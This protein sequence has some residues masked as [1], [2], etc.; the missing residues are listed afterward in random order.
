MA[1][2]LFAIYGLLYTTLNAKT[3]ALL[4]GSIGLWVTLA[5]I[6]YLTRRIDWY[7]HIKVPDKA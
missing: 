6:M 1:A 7:N 3:F 2:V 4:G 5:L